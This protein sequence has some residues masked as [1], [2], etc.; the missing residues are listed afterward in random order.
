MWQNLAYSPS[1]FMS[2]GGYEVS[3]DTHAKARYALLIELQYDLQAQDEALV[4]YL[5]TQE[6]LNSQENPEE[7]V[8]DALI[9][10]AYLLTSFENPDDIPLFYNAKYS[11]FDASF[12]IDSEFM[13]YALGD[14]TET[15][16]ED[17]FPEIYDDLQGIYDPCDYNGALEEWWTHLSSDYPEQESDEDLYTLYQRH[18]YLDNYELAKKY[19]EAWNEATPD[20]INKK[21]VLKYAYIELKEYS[22]VIELL[23]EELATSDSHWDSI[24]CYRDLLDFYTRTEQ[25]ENASKTVDCIDKELEKFSDWKN[26]GLGRM[27]IEQIFGFSL[28]TDNTAFGIKAF[29]IAYKWLRKIKYDLSYVGLDTAL[30]AANKYDLTIQANKLEKLLMAV[31]YR[32]EKD[33]MPKSWLKLFLR[34]FF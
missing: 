34:R 23:K 8:S 17:N 25:S 14:Y 9:L 27:T 4:R 19:L 29:N 2:D 18:F 24:S 26:V 22:Q 7:G 20:S 16:I 5:F 12:A 30:K 10:N 21:S 32:I 15:F 6:I 13:F 3:H 33:L 31:Q 11:N 1:T 28:L